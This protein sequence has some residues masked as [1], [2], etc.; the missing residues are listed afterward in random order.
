MFGYVRLCVCESVS[1]FVCLCVCV[2]VSVSVSLSV[3]VFVSMSVYMCLQKTQV[4]PTSDTC[5]GPQLST[6]TPDT[7]LV[8]LP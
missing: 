6:G 7:L 5:K 8:M 3:S 1:V 2:S 4:T